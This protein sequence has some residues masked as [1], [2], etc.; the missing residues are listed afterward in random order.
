[1]ALRA[2]RVMLC[3]TGVFTGSAATSQFQ[4]IRSGDLRQYASELSADDLKQLDQL[5]DDSTACR[6]LLDFGYALEPLCPDT[7]ILIYLEAADR[8]K[9]LNRLIDEGKAYMYCGIV[10]SDAGKFAWALDYY[11][12]AQERFELAGSLQD[13]A[14]LYTNRGVVYNFQSRWNLAA[15]N[16]YKAIEF[17]DSLGSYRHISIVCGNVGGVLMDAGQP[18]NALPYFLRGYE[19]SLQTTDSTTIASALINVG[20]ARGALSQFDDA[21][22]AYEEAIGIAQATGD[23]EDLYLAN[24]NLSDLYADLKQYPLALKHAHLAY[25]HALKIGRL[26]YFGNA[27]MNLGSRLLETGKLDSAEYY[28]TEGLKHG[29]TMDSRELK[30]DCYWMLYEV[31]K[32]RNQH[33]VALSYLEK[34]TEVSNQTFNQNNVDRLQQLEIEYQTVQKDK[35]LLANKLEIEQKDSRIRQ[36]KLMRNA[37]LGGGILLAVILGMFLYNLKQRRDFY[38][39]EV[40]LVRR[41]QKVNTIQSYL[42]GE[43]KERLRIAKD[44]HDGLSGLL[45]AAKLQFSAVQNHLEPSESARLDGALNTLD[46]ASTEVRRIAHNMMPEM[47]L[48]HGLVEALDSFLSGIR[49][50]GQIEIDFQHFGMENRLPENVELGVY[51]IVQELINNTLKHA[52]ATEIMVQLNRRDSVLGVTVEDNGKGFNIHGPIESNGI[53]LKNLKNRVEVLDGEMNIESAPGKGTFTYFEVGLSQI[54]KA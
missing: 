51:R 31:E 46:E 11:N 40:D 28:L 8:A 18:D 38:K 12:K 5:P 15:E 7:A 36:E 16:Y 20:F 48:N 23:E 37:I 29:I 22:A 21:I 53:G 42:E 2:M 1:M 17:Y 33:D 44:L 35:E 9:K 13:L 32:T 4:L 30:A 43:E 14:N 25:A 6:F 54:S 39:K 50:S 41:E 49:S 3:V 45:A 26:Y 27:A 24:H 52:E 47:L 19:A 34:F 10:S